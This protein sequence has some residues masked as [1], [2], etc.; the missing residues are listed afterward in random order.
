TFKK[1]IVSMLVEVERLAK[2]QAH[3]YL[4]CDIEHFLWLREQVQSMEGW[5]PFRTSFIFI[6]PTAM[7]APW[8]EMGPQRKWQMVLYA[9]KGNKP[10]TRLYAD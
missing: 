3:M 7:R 6:N 8:P 2:A 5:K 10:V 9:V 1:L 4:F